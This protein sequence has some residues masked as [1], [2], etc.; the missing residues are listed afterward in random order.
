[1]CLKP[2]AT[3]WAFL[4]L[5]LHYFRVYNQIYG[6]TAGDQ[7]LALVGDFLPREM[8]FNED[9]ALRFVGHL[10]ADRF[11]VVVPLDEV[12]HLCETLIT[13]S[14]GASWSSVIPL[15]GTRRFTIRLLTGAARSSAFPAWRWRSAW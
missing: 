11:A 6:Y 14:T 3:P 4:C 1:M 5:D 8:V 7:V 9:G 2:D 10:A 12:A 15:N 13:G